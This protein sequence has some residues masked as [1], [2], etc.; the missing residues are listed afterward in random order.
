MSLALT[1]LGE[2]LAEMFNKCL[3]AG[4]V[5]R[6]WKTSKLV[7]LPKPGKYPSSPS[8]YRP[9][10]LLNKVGKLFERV[11]MCRIT[12]HLEN[13]G[14]DI[15]VHQYG[16]R[17]GKSKTDAINRVKCIAEGAVKQGGVSLA[18]S[19]DIVN[20]FNSIPWRAIGEGLTD[21]RVTSRKSSPAI[22]PEELRS[23]AG[24]AD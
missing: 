12:E 14:P 10:C 16:F 8:A 7:L 4:T 11:L 24:G 21:Y 13:V 5:P 15:H 3:C 20:A 9:I 23:S 22:W 17:P 2:K 1:V 18:V 6:C 19:V